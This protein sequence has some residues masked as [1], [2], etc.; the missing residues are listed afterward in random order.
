VGGVEEHFTL[1]GTPARIR[2]NTALIVAGD[3]KKL[4][5]RTPEG[6]RKPEER[7]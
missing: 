6:T 2:M 5:E 1:S 3:L 4:A 7:R